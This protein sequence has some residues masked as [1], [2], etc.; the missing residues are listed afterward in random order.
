MIHW[1]FS[2]LLVFPPFLF[3]HCSFKLSSFKLFF[4]SNYSVF[5]SLPTAAEMITLSSYMG[6]TDDALKASNDG[7]KNNNNYVNAGSDNNVGNMYNTNNNQL[8]SDSTSSNTSHKSTSVQTTHGPQTHGLQTRDSQISPTRDRQ[9]SPKGSRT[10]TIDT[11]RN[12][13]LSAIAIKS[14]QQL[15]QQQQ[16]YQNQSTAPSETDDFKQLEGEI[17][18]TRKEVERGRD[19]SDPTKSPLRYRDQTAPKGPNSGVNSVTKQA[20]LSSSTVGT[21]TVEPSRERILTASKV[22]ESA[23]SPSGHISSTNIGPGSTNNT[24][25]TANSGNNSHKNNYTAGIATGT[26]T[27]TMSPQRGGQ[28]GF[29]PGPGGQFGVSG[30]QYGASPGQN[31]VSGGQYGASP[32]QN[33][34]SGGQYVGSIAN[35]VK[36]SGF[37]IRPIPKQPEVHQ[38]SPAS[39]PQVLDSPSCPLLS[40]RFHVLSPRCCSSSSLYGDICRHKYILMRC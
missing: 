1:I 16:Q 18:S 6:R 17:Y 28:N 11:E 26:G 25:N 32:G 4:L 39:L 20:P 12:E 5:L 35:A 38:E 40:P 2:Y 36:E 19:G 24:N 30:G 7:H 21:M 8:K 27:G 13:K 15:L 31:G 29:S 14:Q 23:L 37:K 3:V 33:G 9:L 22:Y 10:L 34:A